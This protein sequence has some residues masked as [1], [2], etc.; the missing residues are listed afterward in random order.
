MKKQTASLLFIGGIMLGTAFLCGSPVQ[1]ADTLNGQTTVSA[2][3]TAG[4]VTLAI[5]ST[6]DFGSKPLAP[7]VD[8]GSKDLTYKV[9]DYSGDTKGYTLQ[10]KV[11]TVD[12]NRTLGI[13]GKTVDAASAATVDEKKSN[14]FGENAA[15][16]LPATLKYTN[17][18]EK[19]TL[20]FVVDWTLVK[21]NVQP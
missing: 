2:G 14:V 1:A 7:T 20:T 6:L 5:G 8:F 9:T 12:Q 18:T 21:G 3:T 19:K 15:E 16:T 13:N 17:I 4:D 11:E 10:A